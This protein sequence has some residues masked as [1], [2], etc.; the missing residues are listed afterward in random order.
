LPGGRRPIRLSVTA[1]TAARPGRGHSPLTISF[2][3]LPHLN[4]GLAPGFFFAIRFSGFGSACKA[5][6]QTHAFAGKLQSALTAGDPGH[7]NRHCFGAR[8]R[9]SSGEP[10]SRTWIG[11]AGLILQDGA[12]NDYLDKAMARVSPFKFL[13]EVRAETEKVTWPTRRETLITTI[14]VGI[15]VAI[16]SIFF[17]LAD[18]VIRFA[19]TFVLGIAG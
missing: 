17:L 7:R 4:P 13:Q 18:Q 15:M 19:I 11:C 1:I 5:G 8:K 12:A 2:L 14:M 3:L 9:T 6:L 10:N 16:S